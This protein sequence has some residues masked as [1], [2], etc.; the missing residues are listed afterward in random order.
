MLFFQYFTVL[1]AIAG[2]VPAD[3][4]E[5]QAA[6]PPAA[7][8]AQAGD[9]SLAIFIGGREVGREQ[10]HLSRA[11]AEWIITA[12][13]RTVEPVGLTLTRFNIRYSSDWQPIELRLEGRLKNSFLALSTSFGLTTAINEITQGDTTN[14]KTD[15]VSARTVVIPNNVYAAY[16]ALAARLASLDVGAEVP[17]YVAPQV[18]IKLSVKAVTPGQTQTPSGIVTTRRYS[19]SLQNPGR[20][21]DAEI[22]IDERSRFA[23]LEIP[24]ASLLVVRQDL[25]GVSTRPQTVRNPTDEDLMIPA[26]GFNLAATMT[27]P[28]GTGRLRY[29]AVVLVGGSGP[30]DRDAV[31]TGIP[32]FAQLAGMLAERGL[33]VIR[34]DKRGVGQSGGRTETVT[35]DDYADDVVSIVKWL[36]KR[37]DVDPRRISVVGHSEGGW[38]AMLAARREKKISALELMATPGGP[39]AELILEQQRRALDVM[40]ASETE[41]NEKIELQNRIQAA[42][43]TGKGWEDIPPELRKQADIPWFRSLLLFDPAKVMERLK[44][45][46]LITHGALDTQVPPNHADRLAELAKARKKAGPVKVV[47]LPGL[48]HL[49]VPA[50]TGEVSEY[51]TLKDRSIAAAV[52]D[53]IHQWLKSLPDR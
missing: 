18:E 30:V 44:Q 23:R 51:A 53:T 6:Q 8:S 2:S 46:I 10:V 20:A 19:V 33:T 9:A 1:L 38:V 49:L 45:P 50:T 11:G 16:E 22:T 12:T 4:R 17:I 48:N 34:Y 47:Q 27:T 31:V 36:A 28:P 7:S 24:A 42:V 35:L 41:R 32:I 15:Q 52:A 43:V 21:V 5:P 14:Q 29:P 37:K 40:K 25:A 26:T 3:V 39:G 13:G